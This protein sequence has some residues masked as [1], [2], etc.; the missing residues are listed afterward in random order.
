VTFNAA[1]FIDFRLN[2][3]NKDPNFRLLGEQPTFLSERN[4]DFSSTIRLDKLLP[5]TLGLA[6]PLTITRSSIGNS[7]LYL[8]QTG[9]LRPRNSGT[10]Q[11]AERP[12]DVQS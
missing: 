5:N 10:A 11:A 4:V 3:S 7:P 12:D 6:L 8:S 9:H 2:F 1:D